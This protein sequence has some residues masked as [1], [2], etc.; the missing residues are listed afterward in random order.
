MFITITKCQDRDN[1]D[2]NTI[3][4]PQYVYVYLSFCLYHKIDTKTSILT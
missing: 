3:D 2:L 1:F 4:S